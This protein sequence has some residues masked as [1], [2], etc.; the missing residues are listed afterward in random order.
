MKND[1][2]SIHNR[3]MTI[4]RESMGPMGRED[5]TRQL[6]P[7][8]FKWNPRFNY[9]DRDE[10]R[11]LFT[12]EYNQRAGE[13]VLEQNESLE[14]DW[15]SSGSKITR[16]TFKGLDKLL[17]ALEDS[18]APSSEY[19]WNIPEGDVINDVLSRP[20]PDDRRYDDDY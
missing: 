14:N 6:A 15:D 19:G 13:W 12:I 9:W 8:G 4:L 17:N 10:E 7:Y 3:Y 18:G 5:V 11:F 16:W 2:E 1:N 20:E